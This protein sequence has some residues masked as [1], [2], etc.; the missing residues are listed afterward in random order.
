M[1][2][3]MDFFDI[4]NVAK[5]LVDLIDHRCLNDIDGLE[6]PTAENIAEWFATRLS[7][8]LDRLVVCR[9]YETPTCYAEVVRET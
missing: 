1:F 5:P 2:D 3:Y 7:N 4:D 6:N 9:V 8:E